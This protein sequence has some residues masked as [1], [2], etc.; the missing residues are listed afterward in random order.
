MFF[1]AYFWM[2][3]FSVP[4]RRKQTSFEQVS[5]IN[6][7]RISAFRECG[8]PSLNSVILSGRKE[9]FMTHQAFCAHNSEESLCRITKHITTNQMFCTTIDVRGNSFMSFDAEWNVCNVCNTSFTIK[10]INK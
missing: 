4:R 2:S 9:T 6:L 1:R 8:L 5:E 3:N 7:G 10:I